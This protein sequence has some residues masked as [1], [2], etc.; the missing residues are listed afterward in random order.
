MSHLCCSLPRH[1]TPFHLLP[2]QSPQLADLEAATNEAVLLESRAETAEN[3]RDE[4]L[5]Q[6]RATTPRPPLEWED[7]AGV[8]GEPGGTSRRACW[9]R[10]AIVCRICS[11][12]A[13]SEAWSVFGRRKV[14]WRHGESS[15]D[16]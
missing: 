5:A 1:R 10:E 8:V 7:L 11:L 4:A 3:E 12:N 2:L 6:L 14:G 9:G 13:L 16:H 15:V